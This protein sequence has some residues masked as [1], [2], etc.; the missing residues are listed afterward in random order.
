VRTLATAKGSDAQFIPGQ[1]VKID[2]AEVAALVADCRARAGDDAALRVGF[3]ALRW[4][5]PAGG[6][7]ETA[8][9]PAPL[10]RRVA[11]RR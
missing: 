8:A 5:A 7:R 9:A 4:G 3:E 2:R 11:D 6:G 10:R 1:A